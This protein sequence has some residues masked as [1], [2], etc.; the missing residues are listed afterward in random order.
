M[1]ILNKPNF[2]GESQEATDAKFPCQATQPNMM[3]DPYKLAWFDT[4]RIDP[5]IIR[6]KCERFGPVKHCR[7][8]HGVAFPLFNKRKLVIHW[9]MKKHMN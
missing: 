4:G 1:D 7:Q 3:K 8:F 2:G 9:V 5:E 6:E